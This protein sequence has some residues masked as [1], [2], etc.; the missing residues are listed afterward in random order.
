MN[1]WNVYLNGE[2]IDTVFYSK[3]CD[4]DWVL[5]SL[6]NHDGYSPFIVVEEAVAVLN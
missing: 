5:D 1:A 4:K 2:W 6:I 3:I